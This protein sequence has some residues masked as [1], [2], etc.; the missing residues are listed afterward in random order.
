M[1]VPAKDGAWI[2]VTHVVRMECTC[3]V[4]IVTRWPLNDRQEDDLVNE[5]L[6]KHGGRWQG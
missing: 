6:M 3:G 4:V 2:S 5:H 1:S